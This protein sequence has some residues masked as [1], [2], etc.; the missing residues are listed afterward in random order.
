M[1][2]VIWTPKWLLFLLCDYIDKE[3]E[4]SYYFVRQGNEEITEPEAEVLLLA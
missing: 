2:S 3:A 4:N 1:T